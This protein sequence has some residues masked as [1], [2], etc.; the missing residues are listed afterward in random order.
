MDRLNV[1]PPP[2]KPSEP[3]TWEDIERLA[4]HYPALHHAVTLVRRG[5]LTREQAL[6]LAVFALAEAF[7]NL[8]HE[9][10]DRRMR[11]P[12][13]AIIPKH[14]AARGADEGQE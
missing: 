9:A 13:S 1:Y 3:P 2:G 8:F 12:F 4:L 7:Q 10:V 5:D 11:E 6:I 14:P